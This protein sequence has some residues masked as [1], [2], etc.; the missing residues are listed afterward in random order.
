MRIM[1]KQC[2]DHFHAA[3]VDDFDCICIEVIGETKDD[4]IA[5]LDVAILE[6]I[7]DMVAMFEDAPESAPSVS[8]LN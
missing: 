7:I 1:T 6:D 8:P 5:N 2:G 3:L 4:A